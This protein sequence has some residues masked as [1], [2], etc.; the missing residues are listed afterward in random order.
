MTIYLINSQYDGLI[1]DNYFTS[2]EK[3][4]AYLVDNKLAADYFVTTHE[5]ENN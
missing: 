2:L 5:M 1:H 3:A 4:N